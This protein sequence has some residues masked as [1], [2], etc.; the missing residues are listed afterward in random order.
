MFENINVLLRCYC[1]YILDPD[2]NLGAIY[3]EVIL[4]DDT[5]DPYLIFKEPHTIF[6]TGSRRVHYHQQYAGFQLLHVLTSACCL[7][8]NDSC[9]VIA[10]FGFDLFFF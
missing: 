9:E 7:F 2:I 1:T 6:H 10:H 5:V 4:L 3:S 8:F